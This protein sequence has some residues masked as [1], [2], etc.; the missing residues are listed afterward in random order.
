[1][2]KPDLFAKRTLA[3]QTEPLTNGAASWKDAPSQIGLV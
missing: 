1:M 3:S 2:G